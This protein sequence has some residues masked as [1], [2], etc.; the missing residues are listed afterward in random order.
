MNDKEIIEKL[1]NLFG[2]YKAEWLK[3]KVFDLFAEPAYFPA[4]KDNRPCVLQGGRGTGKTT[5]L[6]GLSYQG[7]FALH[8][9]NFEEFDK[10]TFIGIYHRIDTNHV[11]AFVG[12]GISLENW[13]KI[14][15]HY[16]NLIV[17]REIL[18]FLKWHDEQNNSQSQLSPQSCNL[19]ARSLHINE[20]SENS[21][22]L[23]HNLNRSLVDFQA[24]INNI[25]DGELP[26]LSL[27]GVPI[28]IISESILKLDHFKDKFFFILLD[29]YE[30]L[31]DYQQQIINTLIKHNSEFY[32]F[33][34]G[35]R[36]LGWRIKHTLNSNEL[37]HD[38]ADYVK[39]EIEKKL[40]DHNHFKEFAK[41][42]CQQRISLLFTDEKSNDFNIETS[43]E[44]LDVEREAE[45][46]GIKNTEHI[47]NI[48]KLA[49]KELKVIEQL[50]YLYQYLISYW[51]KW[52]NM[53]LS[54][55]LQNYS[56]HKSVW[57]QRYDNYKY[58]LLFKIRKGR[59]K[60]GIQKYYSGWNTYIKLSRGNIRYL[61]EL[62]YRAY[63]KH[64][65]N[66]NQLNAPVNV[67]DQTIA[68]QDVGLK[69][70]MELEGL[71]KNGAQLTKLLLGFGRIFNVLSS[72]EGNFSPER[73]QF[74]IE[75]SAQLNKE[76]DD[77]ITSAVMHLA[78]VRT[79]GNKLTDK[80]HTRDY[81]YAIHPIYAPYFVFSYRQKR[82]IIIQENEFL[83]IINSPKETIKTILDRCTTANDTPQRELPFQLNIFGN[84]Y[85]DKG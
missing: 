24:R 23:L 42:V 14:Y 46:L 74:S 59:G 35:V 68:A 61:M 44:Y 8:K 6:R 43:L 19:I 62:I 13:K 26:K 72:E 79:P 60:G 7:Q 11:R 5:V 48:Q 25:S 40:N 73:N 21:I 67:N 37:L 82:K 29:E 55:A 3:E 81:I 39:I 30:N 28:N 2:S 77:I 4:L 16:F 12:G 85:N 38:P 32:T 41:D 75:S 1:N 20:K 56:T 52:H 45:V 66:G 18:I 70:L 36:E 54:N 80:S 9:N 57:N 47:K 34:I 64:I 49:Q 27:A 83:S 50:P 58:E 33:K 53:S 69:N 51:A 17:C 31:E 65:L 78:L 63:E 76:T 15:S 71:T 22:S 84:Y 10:S